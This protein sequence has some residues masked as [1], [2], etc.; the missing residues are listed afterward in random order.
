MET[1]ERPEQCQVVAQFDDEYKAF[2]DALKRILIERFLMDESRSIEERQMFCKLFC[3]LT[4][5]LTG[6]FNLAK[7]V[8][9]SSSNAKTE[10]LEY[11]GMSIM[12]RL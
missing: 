4:A 2:T 11:F 3:E 6:T 7:V 9:D 8:Q 10:M 12:N 1:K 5:T